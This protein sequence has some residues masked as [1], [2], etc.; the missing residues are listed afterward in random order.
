MR[1]SPKARLYHKA[2]FTLVELMVI[3]PMAILLIAG[4]VGI[5]VQTSKEV[6]SVRTKNN[7]IY[8][9]QDAL[10]RIEQDVESSTQF[11]STTESNITITSPQG[12]DNAT[13]NFQN[14]TTSDGAALLMFMPLTD[15]GPTDSSRQLVYLAGQPHACSS[16]HKNVNSSMQGV[17][18]YFVRDNHLWR[19][20][21]MP[22]NYETAGCSLPWQ[23]PSCSPDVT[24]SFCKTEDIKLAPVASPGDFTVNYYASVTA[25]SPIANASNPS[26]SDTV[27]QTA[28]NGANTIGVS[29]KGATRAGG[30]DV[31]ETLTTRVTR[32]N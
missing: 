5:M 7:L 22:A 12:R 20:V 4:I 8:N 26:S 32:L 16:E 18:A 14:A 28:L 2:G 17:I 13:Q 30:Q 25:S 6:V 9:I 10:T 15:K 23:R 3:V 11:L 31:V 1:S 27:R 19:R 24:N 21:I 29:I